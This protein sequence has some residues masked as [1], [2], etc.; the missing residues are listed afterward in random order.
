MP[1]HL[2]NKKNLVA[3]IRAIAEKNSKVDTPSER[4]RRYLS[5]EG[6]GFTL[7]DA[8]VENY[9]TIVKTFFQ[10]L[11][12]SKKYSE[13]KTEE[14]VREL[15]AQAISGRSDEEISELIQ[16][17]VDEFDAENKQMRVFLP[18]DGIETP[19]SITI[20]EVT[21]KPSSQALKREVTELFQKVIKTTPG[22]KKQHAHAENRAQVF[23][24]GIFMHPTI[25]E[26]LVVAEGNRARELAVTQLR[27]ILDVIRVTIPVIYSD[28]KR[29]EVGIGGEVVNSSQFV[30]SI[31]ESA[32]TLDESKL[33]PFTL[34]RLDEASVNKMRE[35]GFLYA[36]ELQLQKP[37]RE[38]S[39]MEQKYLQAIHWLANAQIQTEVENKVLSLVTCL[40]VFLSP[41]KNSGSPI[42]NTVAEAYAFL[43]I[44][45]LKPRERSNKCIQ[46]IYELRKRAKRRVQELYD[47]RSQISHGGKVAVT[48]VDLRELTNMA[49]VTI[50]HIYDHFSTYKTP[51]D[52]Q[53][54]VELLKL[55]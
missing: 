2:E 4:M 25:A 37:D 43:M 27:R 38:F 33:K 16:K 54:R 19:K 26:Y 10:Q 24:D 31:S 42:T 40:E 45:N 49:Y 50:K 51:K 5:Y 18:I 12:W 55:S 44:P 53:D 7:I 22:N 9:N 41:E 20:G 32:G 23:I 30:A 11:K 28:Q 36:L 8:E 47:L 39:Q 14:K 1:I 17:M 29:V 48:E 13:G 34:F 3:K 52:L 15:V 46:K 35:W 21:F 6:I